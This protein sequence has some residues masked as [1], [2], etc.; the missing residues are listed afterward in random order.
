M[1]AHYN[2]RMIPVSM[3]KEKLELQRYFDALEGKTKYSDFPEMDHNPFICEIADEITTSMTNFKLDSNVRDLVDQK[4]GELIHL[5]N[6]VVFHNAKLLDRTKFAKLYINNLR[7]MFSLSSTALKLF[8]YFISEME[9]K[10]DADLVYMNTQDGMDFCNYSSKS[11]VYRG[12]SELILGGFICKTNRPWLFYVNPKFAFRGDRITIVDQYILNDSKPEQKV[13]A[14]TDYIRKP[15]GGKN[16]MGAEY[17]D[18]LHNE[19]DPE[20]QF[21]NDFE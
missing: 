18:A 5:K 17:N 14:V 11:M 4:T 15:D 7:D 13:S 20:T 2:D 21:V 8:G 12:L 6:E 9:M 1:K 16:T 19:P 3:D 10:K